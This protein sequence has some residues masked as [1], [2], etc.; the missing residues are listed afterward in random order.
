MQ[1]EEH[2][3]LARALLEASDKNFAFGDRVQ[4]SEELWGAATHAVMAVEMQ[5]GWE[6]EM[7]DVL[8]AAVIRLA[9]GTAQPF[10]EV[11]FEAAVKFHENFFD[12]GMEDPE[13]EAERPKVHQFVN[14]VLPMM[15]RS[16]SKAG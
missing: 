1:R 9:E 3:K 6:W 4:G 16:G 13:I 14:A 10:L 2:A 11:G 8:K 7:E 15:K 12:D 5:L